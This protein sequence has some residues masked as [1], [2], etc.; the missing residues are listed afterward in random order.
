M[1]RSTTVLL[2]LSIVTTACGGDSNKTVELKPKSL[3]LVA[4]DSFSI[5]PEAFAA[6]T[7]AT[8]IAVKVVTAGDA[9]VMLEKAILTAG[10]PE[11][12]VMWGVD[13]TL[14]ARALAKKVLSPYVSTELGKLDPNAVALAPKH[15]VTP[16]DEGD[17]CVN[18]DISWFRDKNLDPPSTL[19][20]LTDAKYKDLLVVEN[21]ATS[22]TGLAFM[23]A[24]VA[25]SG[26]NGW[27]QYWKDLGANELRSRVYEPSATQQLYICLNIDTM[28]HAWEGYLKDELER[29]VSVAASVAVWAAGAKYAVGLLANGSFPEADRPIRLAPSRSPDQLARLLEALAVI[30]PLTMGDLAGSLLKESSRLPAGSTVVLIASLLPDSLAGMIIRLHAQ[31]HKVHVLATSERAMT[32]LPKGIPIQLVGTAFSPKRGFV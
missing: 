29:A 17:V 32:V 30:Q 5:K 15:E 3:T 1:R 16:V 2:A 4:Y 27:S 8:G 22:S 18:Y 11:G 13:N 26:E 6:F 23:L 12:D 28:E 10:N 19:D 14:L 21:P 25:K 9:G 24:T 7:A 20:D 31:G